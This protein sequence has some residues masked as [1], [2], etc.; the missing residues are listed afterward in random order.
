LGSE[1]FSREELPKDPPPL[2]A[3]GH[4]PEKS[5]TPKDHG[6]RPVALVEKWNLK[7]LYENFPVD[8]TSNQLG[9]AICRGITP[10]DTLLTNDRQTPPIFPLFPID[11]KY[12]PILFF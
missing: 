6:K 9:R 8:E 2:R 4:L 10:D 5:I 7:W 12:N 1:A 3:G 11:F